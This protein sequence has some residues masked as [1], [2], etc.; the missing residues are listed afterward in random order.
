MPFGD[1]RA[2]IQIAFA[3]IMPDTKIKKKNKLSN[4]K[5]PAR[6]G[7]SSN[8][9]LSQNGDFPAIGSGLQ[10]GIKRTVIR[11]GQVQLAP[12]DNLVEDDSVKG[13]ARRHRSRDVKKNMNSGKANFEQTKSDYN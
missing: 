3:K 1:P 9:S 10:G 7:R 2:P 11:D 5:S 4:S 13:S 8:A 12:L 6:F